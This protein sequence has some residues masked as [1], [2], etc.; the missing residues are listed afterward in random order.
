MGVTAKKG[1]G[2]WFDRVGRSALDSSDS[3]DLR[4]R[5]TL[6]MFASGLMNLAAILWLA[7]YWVFGLKLPTT[8]P[9]AYQ[10]ISAIILVIFLKT[11][12]FDFFRVA[13]LSLFLFAPFIIQ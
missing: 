8:I 12:N 7:I 5:K 13:Q 4:L 11:R 6:L 1:P 10:A 9:L 2:S 3:E